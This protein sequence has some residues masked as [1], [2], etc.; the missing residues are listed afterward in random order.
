MATNIFLPDCSLHVH[1]LNRV[2]VFGPVFGWRPFHQFCFWWIVL[3][4]S[5]HSSKSPKSW[6]TSLIFFSKGF[7][8]FTF[9]IKVHDLFWVNLCTSW[10]ITLKFSFLPVDVQLIQCRLLKKLS[11]IELLS[12][13]LSKKSD[14]HN[15]T[16]V[17]L[18]SRWSTCLSL[19]QYPTVF[20]SICIYLATP[21]LGCGLQDS[22]SC[23]IQ[24]L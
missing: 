2:H 1:L 10:R 24:N 9:Y 22:F 5:H 3:L 6:I 7:Y 20:K 17:F 21:G 8:S 13:F 11:F 4:V 14:Q 23:G 18:G 16:G 15:F 19:C 12:Q